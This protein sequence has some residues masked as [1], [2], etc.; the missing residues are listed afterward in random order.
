[1]ILSIIIIIIIIIP[2]AELFLVHTASEETRGRIGQKVALFD[3]REATDGGRFEH[4]LRKSVNLLRTIQLLATWDRRHSWVLVHRRH[5][6]VFVW[7]TGVNW[8][9]VHASI[10]NLCRCWKGCFNFV[11]FATCIVQQLLSFAVKCW[12][13]YRSSPEIID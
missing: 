2:R 5:P 8:S 13:C 6:S 11:E 7:K 12:P 4:Q 1:M 9:G 3:R 10:T